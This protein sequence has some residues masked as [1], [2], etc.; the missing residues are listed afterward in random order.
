MRSDTVKQGLERI[1]NRA[2]LHATGVTTEQL[3]K[4]FIGLWS[5]LHWLCGWAEKRRQSGVAA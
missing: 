1:P 3:S 4:P 2:L 5:V